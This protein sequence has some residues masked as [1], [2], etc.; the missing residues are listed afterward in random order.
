VVFGKKRKVGESTTF[1][2]DGLTYTFSYGSKIH[3]LPFHLKLLDFIAERYPE[4]TN[5]YS[6]FKSEVEVF[7][8][9]KNIKSDIFMNHVLDYGGYRFFQSSFHPD[10]SG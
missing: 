9:Q 8:G 3:E 7:D 2:L 1:T 4:T 10:E 6:A 5:S